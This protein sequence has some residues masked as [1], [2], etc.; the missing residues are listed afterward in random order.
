MY[1]KNLGRYELW[2][3]LRPE[4]NGKRQYEQ[5]DAVDQATDY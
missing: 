1:D 4:K 2:S 5:S 3:V